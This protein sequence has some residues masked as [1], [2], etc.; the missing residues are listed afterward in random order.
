MAELFIIGICVVLLI[1]Y[2]F[3]I[4]TKFTKIPS[5][6]LLLAVGWLL[7][8]VGGLFNIIVPNLNVILPIL[9]TVGLILIVLEGSLELELNRSTKDVVKKS[10]VIALV[11]LVIIA[12]GFSLFLNY[13][14]GI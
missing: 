10:A 9:G 5:V 12:I 6:I 3:D 2:L 14:W 4:T 11:P 13:E 8:Q 7:N 1:S